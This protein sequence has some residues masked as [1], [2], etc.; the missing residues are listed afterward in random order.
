M[1]ESGGDEGT[2]LSG[3][4]GKG[5]FFLRAYLLIFSQEN[6]NFKTI[7]PCV[8]TRVFRIKFFLPFVFSVFIK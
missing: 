5:R 1:E 7:R 3:L 8:K 2:S 6:V 4:S